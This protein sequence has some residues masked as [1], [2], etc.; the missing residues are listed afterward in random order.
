MD[1]VI[2]YPGQI[3]L[4]TD[5]LNTN[6][7]TMV[8]LA[9]LCEAVFGS[10]TVAYGLTAAPDTPASMRVA[11]GPGE[12]YARTSIDGTAYSSLPADVTRQAV[13]QGINLDATFLTLT[14][15]PTAGHSI[16]YL[17]QAQIQEQD[18]GAVA[19]PY[20]NAAN[21]SVAFSGPGNTGVAQATSRAARVLLQAKAG[22]SAPTGAQA[23]PSPDAGFIGLWVVTVANGQTTIPSNSIAMYPGAPLIPESGVIVGGLQNG[24]FSTCVAGGAANALTGSFNPQIST[25]VNGLS[26]MVRATQAN[27][28]SSPTFAA[29]STP[30]KTIVKGNNQPLSAG[31]ISGAGHWLDLSYD[32]NLDR[33]VLNNPASP[34]TTHAAQSGFRNLALNANGTSA[35]V[36]ITADELVLSNGS[37]LLSLA[38]N[39]N[40]SVS[41]AASGVGGLDTGSIAASTWYAVWVISN[42]STISGLISLSGT[43]PV[44]PAGFNLRALVGW[45]RTDASVNR[46]PLNFYQRGRIAQYR[47]GGNL[48]GL[49]Q[50]CAGIQGTGTA[51]AS[52]FAYASVSTVAFF[53]PTATNVRVSARSTSNQS[54]AVTSWNSFGGD[55]NATNPPQF[56]N[57]GT[58]SNTF[59]SSFPVDLT[60]TADAPQIFVWSDGTANGV[61]ALSWENS[62]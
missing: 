7:N 50:M 23:A 40:T 18:S 38:R 12:I 61:Y 21:P 58:S 43:A 48:P 30:A 14:A 10:G 16:S 37:G 15:P 8:A 45:I 11:I 27:T 35:A 5:L 52:S 9:K 6:R 36:T 20:Y 51:G 4:E 24:L 32:S 3:P 33:W 55:G 44:M 62:L 34:V 60:L 57:R 17:I 19:L 1:R 39:V 28:S 22:V 2:T 56:V 46:F 31:D 26:L 53:P 59:A 13:K 54:I 41:T 49:P 42:G 47:P 29:G 25:L